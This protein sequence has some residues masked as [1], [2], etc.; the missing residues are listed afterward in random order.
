[1]AIQATIP[2]NFGPDT[3]GAYVRIKNYQLGKTRMNQNQKDK[4]DGINA[5]AAEA[6]SDVVQPYPVAYHYVVA[7]I[8]VY[9]NAAAAADPSGSTYTSTHV[10][11]IKIREPDELDPTGDIPNQIYTALKTYLVNLAPASAISSLSDIT[12]V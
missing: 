1:M 8:D 12:D 4:V 7:D 11:R 6:G 5:A 9:P 3:V 2:I 10:D